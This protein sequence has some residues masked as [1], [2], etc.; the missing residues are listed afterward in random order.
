MS[1]RKVHGICHVCGED[2]Q[3]SYE[4]VPPR[5]AYND[6]PL[7]R[8]EMHDVFGKPESEW[9]RG[10]IVQR[11]SGGYTLCVKCNNSTGTWY[12]RDYVEWVRQGMLAI[13]QAHGAL[14]LYC[15]YHIFPLRVLKQIICMFFSVNG[16]R[17]RKAN[18]DLEKFVLSRDFRDYNPKRRVFAFYTTGNI[19]RLVGA[20][21]VLSNVDSG[22]IQGHIF[23]EIIFPPFGYVMTFDSPPPNANMLD[24]THF[25]E[26][27]YNEWKDWHLRLPHL[28]V[29][30]YYPGDYR[31]N[32]QIRDQYQQASAIDLGNP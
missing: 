9:T 25:A 7:L 4:H 8:Q 31:T 21:G 14:T 28:P 16:A 2:G 22:P 1:R 24:I 32:N 5:A 11:G 30:S 19:S 13:A 26:C 3:L 27:R 18:S 17:F 6:R 12:G 20:F 23:S 29:R 10:R 15:P